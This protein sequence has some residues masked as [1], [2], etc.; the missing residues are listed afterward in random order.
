MQLPYPDVC[1]TSLKLVE[2]VEAEAF[3]QRYINSYP[4]DDCEYK[5]VKRFNIHK[6]GVP[7]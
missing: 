4:P 3:L 1:R 7:V 2:D 5:L 6:Y